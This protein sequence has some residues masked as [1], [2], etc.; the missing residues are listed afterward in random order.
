M[1]MRARRRLSNRAYRFVFDYEIS[2]NAGPWIGYSLR[3]RSPSPS[4]RIA[5]IE[6]VGGEVVFSYSYARVAKRS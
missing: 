2:I 1:K 4:V 6:R 5:P 3:S